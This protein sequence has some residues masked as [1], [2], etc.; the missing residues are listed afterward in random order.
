M[1]E[2]MERLSQI[3]QRVV[4]PEESP[5]AP[6]YN[7]PDC[8]DV[9][10]IPVPCR[11]KRCIAYP[12]TVHDQVHRRLRACLSCETGITAEAGIWFRFLFGR[13][14]Q[15]KP[16]LRKDRVQKF[17]AAMS[18]LG[19]GGPRVSAALDQIVESEKAKAIESAQ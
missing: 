1:G 14:R 5:D 13:D 18:G 16:V 10:W 8:Y 6:T 19:P 15:G 17:R 12:A 3:A 9:G 11:V 7:C 2:I 4:L